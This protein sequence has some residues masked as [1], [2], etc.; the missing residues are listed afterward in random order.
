SS[1]LASPLLALRL[2]PSTLIPYTPLFR[3]P[4]PGRFHRVG[5]HLVEGRQHAEQHAQV[6]ADVVHLVGHRGL[7]RRR[8]RGLPGG[9][10]RLAD[11]SEEHTSEL[12]S[13]EKLVC[14]SR[15]ENRNRQ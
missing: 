5:E 2:T 9:G 6:V 14:R 11:R 10:Q 12:Q 4:A 7:E 15:L 13:R 1:L 8:L 3:S